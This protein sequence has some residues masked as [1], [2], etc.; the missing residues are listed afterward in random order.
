M[1]RNLWFH[2][3]MLLLI[4]GCGENQHKRQSETFV[5]NDGR[6]TISVILHAVGQTFQ[7]SYTEHRPGGV[8]VTGEISGNVY[9]DTLQG[10]L[11][12]TPYKGREKRRKAFALLK[13]KDHCILGKGA[14]YIYM[15]IPYFKS[16]TLTFNGHILTKQ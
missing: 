12:Y 16:E 8:L 7:G 6:D 4:L 5:F 10:S 13:N 3:F 2:F 14:S 11:Y 9:Q 1:V 15:G